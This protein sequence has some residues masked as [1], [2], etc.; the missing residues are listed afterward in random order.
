MS[1]AC[2]ALKLRGGDLTHPNHMGRC[3]L[4]QTALWHHHGWYASKRER[5]LPCDT[6]A[7]NRCGR[8]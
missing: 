6:T 5:D 1:H 4:P 8:A 7:D 3:P 2:A